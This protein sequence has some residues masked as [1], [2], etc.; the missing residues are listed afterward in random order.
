MNKAV[1]DALIKGY[2][3]V[4]DIYDYVK[5]YLKENIQC[6]DHLS[7]LV[8]RKTLCKAREG[9]ERYNT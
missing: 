6:E 7:S 3:K 5:E 8:S 9:V 2:D 1:K 4:Q